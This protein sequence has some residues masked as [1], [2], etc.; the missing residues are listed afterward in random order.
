MKEHDHHTGEK[1]PEMEHDMDMHA[2]HQMHEGMEHGKEMKHEKG[3][4]H[5]TMPNG[6]HMAHGDHHAHM[7]A[8]YRKRF[9]ICLAITI[10]ILLLSPMIQ[11]L[12]G[13]RET[14]KF[15]GDLYLL[16]LLS[17]LV[18]F[19]GG[20]PFLKGI[21]VE[22]KTKK[23]G[24]MTL[25]AVAITTAYVYSSAVVFGLKGSIF[26]WELAT[27]VDIM[28]LGHWIEMKSIMGA[29]KALEALAKLMPSDAHKLM[30]DG[31]VQDVPLNEL[32]VGDKVLVK[33]GEKIPA[34]GIVVEGETSVNEAMLTGESN[35]VPK[36]KGDQVTGGAVNGEGSITM[37]VKK[38]GEDSF[39]SQVI[40][41]VKEAQE[42]KSRTQDLANR[43]A[44]WLTVIALV[45]GVVTLFVW[46]AVMSKD[47]A[48]ALERTVTVM[49]ITC[50][51]A[52]GLAVPLVVAVSTALSARNGLLIRNR[53]AFEKARNIQAI[54]FDKTGTLTE[55]KFGVT[56]TIIFSDDIGEKDL[57]KYAASVEAHSEH[58][59]AKG[60][61][62]SSQETFPVKEFKAIPGKGAE[63]EVNG[64]EVKVVSPGYLKEKKISL[65]EERIEKIASQGKTIVFV[66]IDGKLKGAIALADIIRPESKKAISLLKKMG[67]QCM[68]L[69][70]D[71]KQVAKWVSDEIGLDEYFAEVLPQEKSEKVKEVQARGLTVAMTGDGVNDAPALVQAD[72][73]IAIGAGTDVAVESADIIL[74]RSNPLDAVAIIGLARATYKKMIQNLA[75]ATG[76]NAFAIPLAAGVLYKAGILLT[77][78]MGAALMALS[79]VVVA[80]N[81]RFLKVVKQEV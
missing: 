57:L 67:I 1:M 11:G 2:G 3:M 30:P 46:L 4:E 42:S 68:M 47:L 25:I 12:L 69:T 52:L 6:V 18:F 14:L 27:L 61:V 76:Y 41:L 17:S 40:K 38:T 15:T 81:A 7:V 72:V 43:A 49:V 37:E 13:I 62:S 48:F 33:P 10:P 29:S 20:Y 35:P 19:Y 45:G 64:K 36:K 60:I 59:I 53:I 44:F 78:A 56:D 31:S 9:W 5:H 63:G 51:H 34:D 74:V 70:G 65:T 71:N 58:P 80:I 16:F 39:I 77:P 73:G 8:D 23:I 32:T 21:F 28:L 24:M 54:I 26:F 22:I 66:I 75:W 50:P 55:G 79:T